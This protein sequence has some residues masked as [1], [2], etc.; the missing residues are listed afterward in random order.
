MYNAAGFISSDKMQVQHG[1]SA[2]LRLTDAKQNKRMKEGGIEG[3]IEWGR[4]SDRGRVIE[5]G[6]EG[7]W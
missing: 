3:E 7:E 4:E 6:R 5:G 1:S 2:L